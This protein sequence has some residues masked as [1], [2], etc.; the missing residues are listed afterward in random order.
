MSL[1]RTTGLLLSS[2]ARLDRAR[3]ARAAALMLAGYLAAPLVSLALGLFTDDVLA[4]RT[5]AALPLPVMIAA[6]L[7]AQLMLSHF[8]HLDYYELAELQEARLRSELI[9]L[10]SRPATIDHFDDPTVADSIS[11]VRE[12]LVGNTRALEAV[13]QLTGLLAQTAVTSAIL[14]TLNPVL[15][16]LPLTAIPPV[17]IAR[18]AQA[19][20]EHARERSAEQARLQA[21][22]LAL[23]TNASSVKEL[24]ISEAGQEILS[25]YDAAWSQV[26][27]AICRAQT[28]AAALRGLGQLVFAAGYG[29]AIL[30]VVRQAAT[31]HATVGDVVLVITL[32][33]QVSAQ[34]T[35]MV[36]LISSLHTAAAMTAR[37]AF[38]RSLSAADPPSMPQSPVP[39]A[40]R[41]GITLDRVSFS[42]PGSAAPVL[43]GITLHIP[44]GQTLAIVGENGAGKSTLVKLLCGLHAP[45]SGRILIDGTDLTDLDPLRGRTKV[46][47]IFQDFYRLE[48]TLRESAGL[49]ELDLLDNTP[50]VMEAIRKARAETLLHSLP[51]GL[52][53]LLGRGYS[54]GI[55]LSGGQWQTIA[56]ARCLMRDHP[57]LLVLDEPAAAL[58]A[59]AEHALFDRYASTA[60]AA[61]RETGC[62]T[63][64][65]S[66]RFSTV[67]MA[68]TI[69]VLH[70]GQ[71]IEHGTHTDLI[72]RGGLYAE[73]FHLQAGA[74]Q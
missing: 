37:I 69:A 31:G 17:L 55:E 8:A 71:L 7:V 47:A 70:S 32:A 33:I 65:I 9:E 28:A 18:Y 45:S 40:L 22:L 3:L 27:R 6:L 50:A 67:R 74:Y 14:I 11:L 10:V 29:G 5:G 15:A 44:A 64:L 38:L 1:L 20:I 4:H 26:T 43:R 30:I 16:L 56:L 51:G 41:H 12:A 49:G 53:S 57:Q 63:I 39:G 72:S 58:D 25:R 42:Y 34:I 46:A 60:T 36:Q 59:T 54:H 2:A 48:L 68:G 23:S 61:A 19:V 73:L 52:D 66:H 13:L 35:G 62:V 24:R 21:H